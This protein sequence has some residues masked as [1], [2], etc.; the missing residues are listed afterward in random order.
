ME[1]IVL[2]SVNFIYVLLQMLVLTAQTITAITST[3][4]TT[5]TS[6]TTETTTTTTGKTACNP[7]R[8]RSVEDGIFLILELDPHWHNFLLLMLFIRY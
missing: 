2:L 4:T 7:R 5:T 1:I 3:T 6:T 8:R